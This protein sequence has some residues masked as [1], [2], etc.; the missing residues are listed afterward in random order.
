MNPQFRLLGLLFLGGT[1]MD[2]WGRVEEL[3]KKEYRPYQLLNF[4]IHAARTENILWQL[5]NGELDRLQPKVVVV[6]EQENL[7]D[8]T[9]WQDVAAGMKAIAGAIHQ[10]LPDT[11]V[12]LIG[13]FPK[14]PTPAD[15]LRV[16]IASYNDALSKLADNQTTFYLDASQGL[17]DSNGAPTSLPIP[18]PQPY[19]P[20]SF[21]LW[22]DNQRAKIAELMGASPAQK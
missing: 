18:G 7:Y 22:A 5:T 12:L 1:T 2:C 10:K 17:L 9:P 6:Q 13:A 20:A 19:N 15:P 21:Q 8:K 14:G 4:A 3:T 16:K 11:K